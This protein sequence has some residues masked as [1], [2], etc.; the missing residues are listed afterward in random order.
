MKVQIVK[1]GNSR[2]IRLPKTVLEQCHFGDVAE[3]EVLDG[4]VI[5]RNPTQ[6]RRSG[7]EESFSAMHS[8]GDD[9]LY[10]NI[11]ESKWDHKDWQW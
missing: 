2:G 1:I 11:L 6:K 3:L 4:L 7:W 8:N 9:V 10:D 5:L